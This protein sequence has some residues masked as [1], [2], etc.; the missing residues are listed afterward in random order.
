MP[1]RWITR[2]YSPAP[3]S[4]VAARE[5][6]DAAIATLLEAAT[7]ELGED[8]QLRR[9]LAEAEQRQRRRLQTILLD[10]LERHPRHTDPVR[11]ALL[12]VLEDIATS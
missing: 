4:L 12:N 1:P 6:L 7:A 2:A 9:A 11:V 10:H 5:Q 3:F 8:A